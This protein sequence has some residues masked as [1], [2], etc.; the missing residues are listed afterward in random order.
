MRAEIMR[1]AIS[2]DSIDILESLGD[3][4]FQRQLDSTIAMELYEAAILSARYEAL[5]NKLTH[6]FFFFFFF[7][8][9]GQYH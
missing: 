7:F 6:F 1:V 2:L 4:A 3:E 8:F 5:G 9:F